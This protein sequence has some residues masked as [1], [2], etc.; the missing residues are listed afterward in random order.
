MAVVTVSSKSGLL[1]A[2]ASVSAGDTI[3]LAPGNY[4]SISLD[5]TQYSQRY[6]KYASDVT[7]V[8]E[9]VQNKAVIEG[10]NL[11]GVTHL[12]FQQI[13]FD[14]TTESNSTG[15][16]F[17][18]N[19]AK[20]VTFRG[21]VFSG[22]TDANGYGLGVALKVSQGND[23]M[24]ENSIFNGFR[25]GIEGWGAQAVTIQ[26]NTISGISYDGLVMG[27]MQG[28]TIR[29]N[30]ITM[31]SNPANDD[32]RDVIQL[33]NVGTVAP[34]SNVRIESNRLFAGDGVTHG[35]FMDNG[36]AKSTGSTSEYYT[37]VVIKN[38]VIQTGQKL[39]IA[40]G[41]TNGLNITGNTLIQHDDRNNST[42]EIWIPRLHVQENSQNVTVQNNI[43]H[44]P[45]IIANQSW[46]DSAGATNDW[47][48]SGN[49]IVKVTW[50]IGQSTID[51]WADVQG[52]GEA[53]QFRF[54]GT[55]VALG[56]KVDQ[57]PDVS[58][59]EGDTI[60]LINY[61]SGSF[62]GVWK[63][64]P[65]DV[66]STGDYVKIDSIVDI[67]ELVSVSPKVTATVSNDTLT[68]SIVQSGGTHD[69][70]LAGL[71]DAYQSN[72]DPGLF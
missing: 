25:K 47:T 61:E 64:N 11:R 24:I 51:P 55:A 65:L 59:D 16:P 54:K 70:V 48:V 43:L 22:E 57:A 35:I 23:I 37:N 63:G 72:Y 66:N 15:Y 42:S 62:K 18:V 5:A 50:Q 27:H 3:K 21:N 13:K 46:R 30:T 44:G 14:Y 36:D 69:I 52:N 4:G 26:G 56:S 1:S 53:D 32:H 6:L 17:V 38:N 20:Y 31:K 39:G 34:S 49:P 10:L 29:D 58:F 8:S 60:V 9:N 2:L 40:V 41:E 45:V 12:K 7:I 67:Q 28:L 71:G 19:G 33:Y 68:L